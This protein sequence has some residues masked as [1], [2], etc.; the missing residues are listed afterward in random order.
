M[1]GWPSI[2]HNTHCFAFTGS[3]KTSA[4]CSHYI[5]LRVKW[6][7]QILKNVPLQRNRFWTK[8]C[9]TPKMMRT[10]GVAAL[11]PIFFPSV[12]IYH[13]NVPDHLSI[14]F[15]LP[16]TQFTFQ[17]WKQSD[18]GK[19]FSTERSFLLSTFL[20]SQK[21]LRCTV[22]RSKHPFSCLHGDTHSGSTHYFHMLISGVFFYREWSTFP[23]TLPMLRNVECS[24]HFFC[25]LF[26]APL[27]L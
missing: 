8:W 6:R 15:K 7:L 18:F 13:L 24:F 14:S 2:T 23:L 22:V 25:P 26:L 21:I 10:T 16:T 3:N 27:I 17:Q 4:T 5:T 9:F 1:N 11:K 20:I 12:Q 19:P